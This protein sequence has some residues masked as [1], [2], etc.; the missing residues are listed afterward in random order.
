MKPDILERLKA[1]MVMRPGTSNSDVN[2]L[3]L[4]LETTWGDMSDAIAEIE[5]LRADIIVLNQMGKFK[6]RA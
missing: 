3:A 1:A 2:V 5:R 6:E 4:P